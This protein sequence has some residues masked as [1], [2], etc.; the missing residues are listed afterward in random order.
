MGA[1]THPD[2]HRVYRQLVRLSKDSVARDLSVDVIRDFLILP[3]GRSAQ[4]GG[5]KVFVIE[6][7]DTMT[8]AAQNALLKTLEEPPGKAL[9]ILLAE[10]EMSL[11]PTIRSRCQLVRFAPLE[12][13]LVAAELERRGHAPGQA[14]AAAQLSGGSLGRALAFLADDV[15]EMARQLEDRLVATL[16]GQTTGE[17]AKLLK[18]SADTL[19]GKTLDRDPEGSKDQATR[20][21]L[22]LLLDLAQDVCRRHLRTARTQSGQELLCQAIDQLALATTLLNSNVNISLT[23]TTLSANLESARVPPAAAGSR[24]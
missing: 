6:E 9:L 7:A 8:T 19:A 15:P 22:T 5:G 2:F 1:G 13:S 12:P 20:E 10:N 3:A 16:R 14:V 24:N 17:L 23:L 21:A 11:L 18:D 4:L